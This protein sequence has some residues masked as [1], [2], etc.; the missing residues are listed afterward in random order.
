M[1]RLIFN[2]FCLILTLTFSLVGFTK[3]HYP[4]D[5]HKIMQRGTLIVAMYHKDVPPFFMHDKKTH[6]L[7]GI[8]V[9]L[10]KD[11]AKKL[12]VHVRFERK[13]QTFDQIV[14]AVAAHQADMAISFLTKTL[15]RAK[16][17]RFTVPYIVLHHGLIINRVLLAKRQNYD[18]LIQI[19]NKPDLKIGVLA[20]SAY[21][22]I[23]R[24]LFPRAEIVVYK[25]LNDVVE[26]V[27]AG[28]VIA[29]MEDEITLKKLIFTQPKSAIMVKTV[30][31]QDLQDRISMAVPW[32]SIYLAH[33]LNSY[34]EFYK[35]KIDIDQLIRQYFN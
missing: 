9:M 34:L 17:V 20:E 29:G 5:I 16:K 26:H 14:E 27:K 18:S 24:D 1:I 28:N 12:G 3:S 33:W 23:A 30:L 13:Y 10:A 15:L 35:P 2:S 22:P 25:T 8:D 4:P 11:I 21:V 7:I 31:I 6:Q 32:D 19:L